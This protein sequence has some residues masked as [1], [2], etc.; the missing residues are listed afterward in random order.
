M[1]I[2]LIAII[3]IVTYKIDRISIVRQAI[4]PAESVDW[5]NLLLHSYKTK[6]APLGALK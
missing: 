1:F 4:L 2:L 3:L 6:I 5:V